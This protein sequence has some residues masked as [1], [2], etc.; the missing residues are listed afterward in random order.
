MLRDGGLIL[1][2]LVDSLSRYDTPTH[3]DKIAY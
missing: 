3:S 2:P 1:C